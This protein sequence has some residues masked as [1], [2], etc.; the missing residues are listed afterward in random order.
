MAFGELRLAAADKPTVCVCIFEMI[1]DVVEATGG[2]RVRSLVPH[3]RL[4]LA[5][6]EHVGMPG[7]ELQRVRTAYVKRFGELPGA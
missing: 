5:N 7:H 2:A 3:A 1:A 4:L 6:A